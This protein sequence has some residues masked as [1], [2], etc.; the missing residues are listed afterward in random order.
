MTKNIT[1][2]LPHDLAADAEASARVEGQS[3]EE[4]VKQSLAATVARR[5]KDPEF[6]AR[7]VR[8]IE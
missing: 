2:R 7:V 1:V 8:I 4:T 3:L 5:R 6:Q